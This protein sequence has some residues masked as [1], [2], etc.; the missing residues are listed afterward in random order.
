[1]VTYN[2]KVHCLE[3]KNHTVITRRNG[4][5]VISGNSHQSIKNLTYV[6]SPIQQDF[7]EVGQQKGC[8]I[9]DT[10]KE[11]PIEFYANNNLPEFHII[12][13][14][15]NGDLTKFKEGYNPHHYYRIT[16]ISQD[17]DL[18]DVPSSERIEII[19][20]LE[21]HKFEEE[22]S[23]DSIKSPEQMIVEVIDQAETNVNKDDW[24]KTALG[25]WGEVEK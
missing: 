18:K 22:K 13:L 23:I 17:V 19:P 14:A 25:I 2:G 10:K 5:V 16:I 1:M 15:S 7:E 4:K 8:I 20:Y 11:N 6:G 12:T 3:T 24:K 21:E 9:I